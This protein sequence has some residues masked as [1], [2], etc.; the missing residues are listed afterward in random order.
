MSPLTG[1][2]NNLPNWLVLTFAVV[3]IASWVFCPVRELSLCQVVT[4]TW[5]WATERQQITQNRMMVCF[6]RH[7]R[8]ADFSPD[9]LKLLRFMA[10]T[11]Q[12]NGAREIR[13]GSRNGSYCAR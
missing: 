13:I 12:T 6:D 5:A 7:S 1:A 8:W 4:F 10:K 3:S 9:E 2:E 11:P